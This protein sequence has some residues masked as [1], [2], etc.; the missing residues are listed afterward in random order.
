MDSMTLFFTLYMSQRRH[1][2]VSGFL[3]DVIFTLC[4]SQSRHLYAM[5]VSKSS[6]VCDGCLN[7]V[8]FTSQRRHLY[9]VDVSMTLFDDVVLTR[10]FI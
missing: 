7:D 4:T 5:D 1:S 10:G 9:V 3:N 6:F 2:Y 8:I